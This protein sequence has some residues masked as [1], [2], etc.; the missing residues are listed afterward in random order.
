M[1]RLV[2]NLVLAGIAGT[3][4]GG[5]QAVFVAAAAL[6]CA[7]AMALILAH[8]AHSTENATATTGFSST[9]R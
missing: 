4:F 2:L 1:A 9:D 5:Y 3:A 8:R 7:S 6:C